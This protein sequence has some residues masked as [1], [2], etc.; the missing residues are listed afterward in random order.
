MRLKRTGSIV[1]A[2]HILRKI[3]PQQQHHNEDK[4]GTFPL[5]VNNLWF[6]QA[7]VRK[8]DVVQNLADKT[9][10]V[11]VGNIVEEVDMCI[12]GVTF[13]TIER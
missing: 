1:L 6:V 11:V 10:T 12:V 13:S 8:P 5:A 4:N 9:E 7:E 2:F 3:Y